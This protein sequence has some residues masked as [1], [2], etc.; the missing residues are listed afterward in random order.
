MRR[1]QDG[2]AL[3]VILL[4]LSVVVLAL[5]K[6]V[7]AWKTEIQRERENRMI[8]HAREYRMAIKRYF[9]KNGRYPASIDVLL[10]KDGNG[11]RY[12]RQAWPDPLNTKGDAKGDWDI[13]HFGQAVSAKIVDQPPTA[14]TGAQPAHDGSTGQAGGNT[15][16]TTP[17]PALG[18]L[19][20]PVGTAAA[21][22]GQ[23][24][25]PGTA[26]SS[27]PGGG[28]VIGV[29]SMNKQAAVHSFNGFD[30]PNDWQFVYSYT[31]DPS[32][33]TLGGA[34]GTPTGGKPQTPPG[35][36]H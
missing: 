21:L 12:L 28:P 29:A 36:G 31:M 20:T 5:A 19:G 13:I 14:A 11:I 23:T 15:P 24:G 26:A 2:Y 16:G 6:A 32:L 25:A 27:G 30:T 7:P 17:T 8:D 34:G 35:P 18:A 33:R 1:K 4:A 22:G 9:H 10:Q 3:L